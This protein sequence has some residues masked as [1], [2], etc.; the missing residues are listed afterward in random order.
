MNV[1]SSR[2]FRFQDLHCH[3][4]VQL[5]IHSLIDICH[6]ASSDFS[7]DLI[8]LGYDHSRLQH[9]S[10]SFVNGSTS[11][12]ANIILTTILICFPKERTALLINICFRI[13]YDLFNLLI[14]NHIAETI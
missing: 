4:A 8:A 11:T 2:K 3:K 13:G 9:V 14:C 7:Y 5:M 6:S 12:I 1:V 10:T